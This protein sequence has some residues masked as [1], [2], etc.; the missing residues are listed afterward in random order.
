VCQCA[1]R[2]KSHEC[3]CPVCRA[4][5]G[6]RPRAAASDDDANV[7]PC[8]R[9]KAAAARSARAHSDRSAPSDERSV[10]RDCLSDSCGGTRPV[11]ALASGLE[12]FTLTSPVVLS[13]HPEAE[14]IVEVAAEARA[15]PQ[16]PELP[17]PRF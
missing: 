15:A 9:A 3:S 7:P 16:L 13:P 12:P 1:A 14:P 2:G 6:R 17:P 11:V 4:N 5:E 10:E 8:H